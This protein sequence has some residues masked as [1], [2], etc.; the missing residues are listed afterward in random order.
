MRLSLL[1]EDAWERDPDFWKPEEDIEEGPDMLPALKKSLFG[2]MT[3]EQYAAMQSG[4]LDKAE[5]IQGHL[6]RLDK[7]S[8]KE[9]NVRDESYRFFFIDGDDWVATYYHNLE[10]TDI[11][12][13]YVFD[14]RIEIGKPIDWQ[15]AL[16]QGFRKSS[17]AGKRGRVVTY[18]SKKQVAIVIHDPNSTNEE[19]SKVLWHP[20]PEDV[21]LLDYGLKL[22]H[23]YNLLGG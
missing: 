20:M 5:S 7:Y 16:S 6:E 22:A 2:N 12:F 15:N 21:D 10:E 1:Y 17:F 13:G 11:I 19:D 23:K 18:T 4:I 3:P 8:P 9:L 14:F